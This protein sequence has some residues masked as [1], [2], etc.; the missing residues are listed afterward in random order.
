M[1][2]AHCGGQEL[3]AH[4][5]FIFNLFWS[6]V[7]SRMKLSVTAQLGE[8]RINSFPYYHQLYETSNNNCL[9]NSKFMNFFLLRYQHY[10]TTTNINLFVADKSS[11]LLRVVI[12][13]LYWFI[14][15]VLGC[16]DVM[17]CDYV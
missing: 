11:M 16:M 9:C 8:Q 3:M 12:V 15:R 4:L 17:K 14:Y 1:T 7:L 5:H 2:L 6:I 10:H 13:I